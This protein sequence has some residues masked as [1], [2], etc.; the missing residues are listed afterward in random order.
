[1][2]IKRYDSMILSF[3][4][5]SF[6]IIIFYLSDSN[7]GKGRNWVPCKSRAKT[8]DGTCKHLPCWD[9]R[10]ETNCINSR[11]ICK[12]GYYTLDKQICISCPTGQPHVTKSLDAIEYSTT[13]ELLEPSYSLLGKAICNL[14]FRLFSNLSL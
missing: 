9:W 2:N 10:G 14:S 12:P 13:S 7:R 11:C 1:M 5:S 8:T 4:H 6:C 3:S